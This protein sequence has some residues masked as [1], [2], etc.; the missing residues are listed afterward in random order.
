[1]DMIWH[2]A[3]GPDFHRVSVAPLGHQFDIGFIIFIVEK[4]LHAAVTALR[5]MVRKAG[6]YDAC[7]TGHVPKL[8]DR[9]LSVKRELSMVS[10]EMVVVS[11]EMAAAT[12]KGIAAGLRNTG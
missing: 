3:I 6:C 5:N 11:P 4:G 12:I 10:A 9:F 1:M 8:M 7:D 2:E